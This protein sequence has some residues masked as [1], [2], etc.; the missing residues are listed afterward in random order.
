MKQIE[1]AAV[2][3]KPVAVHAESVNLLPA[4]PYTLV[5]FMFFVLFQAAREK[6]KK[7]G[8]KSVRADK[9]KVRNLLFEA[10]EKHQYYR[11]FDLANLT[12]QPPV[13][14]SVSLSPV[15][16]SAIANLTGRCHCTIHV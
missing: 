9:D 12:Q 6:L 8:M 14:L 2:K 4:V 3:F 16:L 1:K 5:F 15:G 13:S 10:F 7:M 11:L